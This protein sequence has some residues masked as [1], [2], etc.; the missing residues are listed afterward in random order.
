VIRLHH[1][2][3]TA[4]AL[5]LGCLLLSNCRDVVGVV[6]TSVRLSSQAGFI[7]VAVDDWTNVSLQVCDADPAGRELLQEVSAAP[8]VA[9]VAPNVVVQVASGD[10]ANAIRLEQPGQYLDINDL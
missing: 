5:L 9:L 2:A 1:T 8:S 4:A 7:F 6:C 3:V 10:I